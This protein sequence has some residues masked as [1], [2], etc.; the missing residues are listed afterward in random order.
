MHLDDLIAQETMKIGDSSS[1]HHLGA[2]DALRRLLDTLWSGVRQVA[3]GID[4]FSSV[5][6]GIDVPPDHGARTSGTPARTPAT[7]RPTSSACSV[8]TTRLRRAR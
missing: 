3:W 8:A 7:G 6:H 4:A 1:A 2:Q 5:R